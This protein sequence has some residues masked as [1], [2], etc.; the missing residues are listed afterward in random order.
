MDEEPDLF[1][2]KVNIFVPAMSKD[3]AYNLAYEMMRGKELMASNYDIV[4]VKRVE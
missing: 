3:E 1:C 2:V 4:K